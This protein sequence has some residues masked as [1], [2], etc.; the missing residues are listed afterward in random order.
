M[1]AARR[2]WPV[3]A[4]AALL[5]ANVFVPLALGDVYPFTSAPMFRDCPTQC[6][7]YR[8]Y[9]AS[10]HELPAEEW[11][12]QRIYDGNPVGYGV[13]LRPPA[14]VEKQFGSIDSEAEVRKHIEG[15]LNAPRHRQ[16]GWV[17]VVQ[18]VIAPVDGRRVGVVRTSRWRVERSA[19]AP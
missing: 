10:G 9:A 19:A 4:A 2:F 1:D 17:E 7:N 8:V 16:H 18:E 14:V 5:A 12:V 13:G 3:L 11:L 15:Q 6:V